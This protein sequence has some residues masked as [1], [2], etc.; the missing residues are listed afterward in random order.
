M[1][2]YPHVYRYVM[3]L[4]WAMTERM[5]LVMLDVITAR[6]NYPRPPEE[7]AAR[8]A[9]RQMAQTPREI[10]AVPTQIAVIP[11]H[12][13]IAHRA[14][15]FNDVSQSGTS[16]E[17][18]SAGLAA[19]VDDPNV[20]GV[21]LEID[22]EGGAV[23][24]VPELA[25]EIAAAA[26]RKPVHAIANTMAAS[27]AF[28]LG[29]QAGRFSMTPSAE[30]GSVGV[31]AAHADLSGQL[32]MNGVRM[33]L[34]SAGRFKTEGHP[35]GPLGD[36]A[37]AALQTRVDAVHD[38]FIRDLARGRRVAESAVRESFG[39]GRLMMPQAALDAGM[40]DSVETFGEAIS[41]LRSEIGRGRPSRP[42][43]AHRSPSVQR[44]R[45][46]V[47][48]TTVSLVQN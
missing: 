27:A 19:A 11:I 2:D 4:P 28:W 7:I 35:F 25:G 48:G 40:V 36:E 26:R 9:A 5:L 41:A 22:S 16:V 34:I 39:E 31:F 33:T 42:S 23:S 43:V 47:A 15:Q 20:G 37:L 13:V 6:I 1:R 46:V 45:N 21:L 17:R 3:S 18:V 32:E 24:G 29:A 44:L 10:A 38:M 8:I 12:G 30:V 14:S